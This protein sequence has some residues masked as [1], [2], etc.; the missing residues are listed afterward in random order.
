MHNGK[1]GLRHRPDTKLIP[2]RMGPSQERKTWERKLL[3]GTPSEL[4]PGIQSGQDPKVVGLLCKGTR[5]DM[6]AGT[7]HDTLQNTDFP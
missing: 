2:E 1:C 7:G 4:N 5:L 3:G 6:Q